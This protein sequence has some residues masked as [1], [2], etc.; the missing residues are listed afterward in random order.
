MFTLHPRLDAD[1]SPVGDLPLCRVLMLEDASYPWLILVP[2]LPDMREI[3]GLCRAQQH[4]LID[5]SSQVAQTMVALFQPDKMNVAALGNL[6]PQL[7][8]H[9]VARFEADPAWPGPVW[10]AAPPLAYGDAER[11][12]RLDAL[13]SA[14][15][16]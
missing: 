9:H 1:C 12:A 6:V 11:D 16:I 7:H 13:R 3:H 4:Q 14:L 10:G 15:G 8:L 5:E 2:R